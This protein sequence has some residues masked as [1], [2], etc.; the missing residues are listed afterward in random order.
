MKE[1]TVFL[2]G[3][4]G[5]TLIPMTES[6][7]SSEDILQALLARYPD[8][9]PGDQIAPDNPRRWLLVKR[10]MGV[11]GVADGNGRWSLDHLFL[12]QDGIPTFVECKRATDTRIRREVVAQVLEYAA[13]GVSYWPV[14]QLRQDAVETAAGQGRMLDDEVARLIEADEPAEI[15]AYWERVEENLTDGRVRLLIV[16]DQIPAELRRLVEF[17]N[18]K[19]T[20]VEVLAVEVKQF[21][22]GGQTAWVPRVIGQSE[23]TRT[24]KRRPADAPVLD[25]GSFQ[26]RLSDD[27]AAFYE[28][29]MQYAE[30]RGMVIEWGTE[31]L[32]IKF[33]DPVSGRPRGLVYGRWYDIELFLNYL[34]FDDVERAELAGLLAEAGARITESGGTAKVRFENDPDLVTADRTLRLLLDEVVRRTRTDAEGNRA[35]THG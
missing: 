11:P 28:R 23:A 5:D 26:S 20:D 2:A 27:V 33:R 29:A 4:H 19:M 3:N 12:D 15:Q 24:R 17:L 32:M 25:W 34:P 13:N 35:T 8:L 21:Q 18:Q 31:T 16:A 14:D 10:E 6:A 30:E 1:A 7:Y 9:L 22:G